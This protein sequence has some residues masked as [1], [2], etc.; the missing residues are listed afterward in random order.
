MPMVLKR[1]LASRS[2]LKR[3]L[4]TA[5][6]PGHTTAEMTVTVAVKFT[7]TFFNRSHLTTTENGM[8]VS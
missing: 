7:V 4:E 5:L 1:R 6:G 8:A 3:R 2:G